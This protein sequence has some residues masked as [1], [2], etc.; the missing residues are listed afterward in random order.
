MPSAIQDFPNSSNFQGDAVVKTK[1]KIGWCSFWLLVIAVLAII[2]FRPDL[3]GDA[4]FRVQGSRG[5]G[6]VDY[7]AGLAVHQNR[8]TALLHRRWNAA[9]VDNGSPSFAPIVAGHPEKF[10][11]ENKD[12]LIAIGFGDHEKLAGPDMEDWLA[13]KDSVAAYADLARR[14]AEDLKP[15]LEEFARSH[16]REIRGK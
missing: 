6:Y 10:F 5:V 4:L 13:L 15:L 9:G 11:E 7:D 16:E 8:I 2:L 3:V 12:M 1:S 14:K